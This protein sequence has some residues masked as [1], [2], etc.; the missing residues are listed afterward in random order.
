MKE[1]LTIIVAGKGQQSGER[2]L[3]LIIPSP[4]Q[5]QQKAH[6]LDKLANRNETCRSAQMSSSSCVSKNVN[7]CKFL[8]LY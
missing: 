4:T 3:S 5:Q 8:V 6:I 1:T 7:I 2:H